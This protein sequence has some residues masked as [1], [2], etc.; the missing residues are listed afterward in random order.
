MRC[1]SLL[2]FSFVVGLTSATHAQRGAAG[3]GAS[4]ARSRSPRVRQTERSETA[5]RRR[6][7]RSRA[8][9][10]ERSPGQRGASAAPSAAVSATTN[11]PSTE[12]GSNRALRTDPRSS[13]TGSMAAASANDL[14]LPA[15][16]GPLRRSGTPQAGTDRNRRIDRP[17][18]H[19]AASNHGPQLRPLDPMRNPHAQQRG[20]DLREVNGWNRFGTHEHRADARR[21]SNCAS[22]ALATALNFAGRATV[23]VPGGP[24]GHTK[25]LQMLQHEFPGIGPRWRTF[26]HDEML[27][28]IRSWGPNMHGIVLS[29][30]ASGTGHAY[31]VRTT[32][33]GEIRFVDG[34]SAA[35]TS[36]HQME[37]FGMFEH[38]V[39]RV[40]RVQRD[41]D[42]STVA[43]ERPRSPINPDMR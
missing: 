15:R 21:I 24:P 20:F 37:R 31:N 25:F 2:L 41:I 6:M 3:P 39:M 23:A 33:S 11:Q 12:V 34:Q 17:R 28:H 32:A 9:Q 29:Y 35:N 4:G 26:P 30:S 7:H 19:Q 18:A 42:P 5:R 38:W 27:E 36:L 40:G 10:P 14:T 16:S 1:V 13:P 8:P 43:R 22:C